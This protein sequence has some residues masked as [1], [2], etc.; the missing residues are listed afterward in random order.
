MGNNG[1]QRITEEENQI[2][3]EKKAGKLTIFVVD[4]QPIFRHGLRQALSSYNGMEVVG[5]SDPTPD[6]SS[7]VESL[8][9]DIA[10]VDVG[11]Q[12]AS[13]FRAAR[14]IATRCPG[15]AVV[16]L[17]AIP[18]DDQLFQA[19]K[20]GAV[21]L[22]SKDIAVDELAGIL[23]RIGRGEYPI[24]DSLLERP[25]T[26][27]QVLQL[28]QSFALK[29]MET[30]ITPLSPREMEILKYVA[31]GNPNKS[32]AYALNI[33]EQTIKNYITSIMRKLNANDRTHAVVLAI[34]NGW[35]NVGEVSD[36]SAREELIAST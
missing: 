8:S 1:H 27:K 5:E 25:S 28:F 34:R 10:L 35:L 19:I 36:L 33:S 26:A 18:D 20:S 21:A 6:V 17:V 22:L 7:L 23:R 3:Q 29:D 32:I 11:T 2:P 15:V 24:N 16:I 30:L 9:P 13:G 12:L 14:Q 31:E 4:K